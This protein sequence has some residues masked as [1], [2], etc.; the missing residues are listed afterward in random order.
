MAPSRMQ[1]MIEQLS[2]ITRNIDRFS[3]I[4]LLTLAIACLVSLAA[5]DRSS[6]TESPTPIQTVASPANVQVYPGF[7]AVTLTWDPVA[8]AQRYN[9]YAATQSG[10]GPTNWSLMPDGEALL[11]VTSPYQHMRHYKDATYYYVVTAEANGHESA[12]SAEASDP[13]QYIFDDFERLDQLMG[14]TAPTGQTWQAGGPGYLT[15]GIVDGRMVSAQ[16]VYPRLSY[17]HHNFRFG[18]SFSFDSSSN[19]SSSIVLISEGEPEGELEN[20]VH[21]QI[22]KS[23]WGLLYR[24]ANRITY[25]AAAN[26]TVFSY[27]FDLLVTQDYQLLVDVNGSI[28]GLN[29][30]YTVTGVGNPAGGSVIFSTPMSGGEI[31]KIFE[32]G[33]FEPVAAG[34][35]TLAAD[36]TVYTAAM[37]IVNDTVTLDLPDGTVQHVQDSR[38]PNITGNSLIWQLTNGGCRNESVYATPVTN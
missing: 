8:G 33:P 37:T 22:G 20:M 9:L 38:I 32:P 2:V 23:G 34:P 19:G 12:P 17:P 5:C 4:N 27:P 26:E 31:V 36:G 30:D 7:P 25:T 6:T 3:Y 35:L 15:Y 29:T 28:K 1:R 16:N 10:V 13:N 24:A 14:G 11:G 18:A 21:L